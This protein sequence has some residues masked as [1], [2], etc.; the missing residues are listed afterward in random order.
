MVFLECCRKFYPS[1]P[2][3]PGELFSRPWFSPTWTTVTMYLGAPKSATRKR[4]VVQNC[5]VR[6]LLGI[7][8]TQLARPGLKTLHW[9]PIPERIQFKS[10]CI[11]HKT[12]WG[13]GPSIN[14]SLITFYH[15]RKLL[16]SANLNL[17]SIPKICRMRSRGSSF[18]YSIAR[19]WNTLPQHLRSETHHLSFRKRLKTWLFQNTTL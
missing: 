8:R 7:P 15:P 18:S 14:S 5:A 19:L 6:L 4:Q 9:L 10:L 17:A 1:F 2:W 12:L 13:K 11:A 3:G 16:C